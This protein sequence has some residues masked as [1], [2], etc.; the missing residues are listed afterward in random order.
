MSNGFLNARFHPCK[1]PVR[2][3]SIWGAVRSANQTTGIMPHIAKMIDDFFSSFLTTP[4]SFPFSGDWC[5][6]NLQQDFIYRI[7]GLLLFN[8]LVSLF[9]QGMD[10]QTVF[11]PIQFQNPSPVTQASPP[12]LPCFSSCFL[13]PYRLPVT[14]RFLLA[15]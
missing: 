7:R 10:Q 2:P 12:P 13:L 9:V 4:P 11:I 3:L 1:I 8:H 6:Y 5:V 14:S 15:L